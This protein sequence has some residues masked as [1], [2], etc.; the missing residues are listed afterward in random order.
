MRK[1]WIVAIGAVALTV[2]A[3]AVVTQLRG[4]PELGGA[5]GPGGNCADSI[6][7]NGQTWQGVKTEPSGSGS[8]ASFAANT[9]FCV[10]AG[11]MNSGVI[12][13]NPPW[14]GGS[15]STGPNWSP[16]DADI[17]NYVVYGTVS[18]PTT[19]T[20]PET[21]TTVPETTTTVPETTTTVVDETTT[22]TDPE[23]PELLDLPTTT[24]EPAGPEPLDV[25]TVTTP[26]EPDL[27]GVPGT[28]SPDGPEAGDGPTPLDVPGS[29]IPANPSATPRLPVTGSSLWQVGMLAVGMFAGGIGLRLL[30]RRD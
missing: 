25:P 12:G 30:T 24:T 19:T 4:D 21:T 1:T 22:T 13:V 5:D 14:P 7:V 26:E 28:V 2:G 27:N 29:P 23:E 10:K 8:S 6:E 11:N 18:P 16:P 17:S 15:Y 20:V 3:V 9:V